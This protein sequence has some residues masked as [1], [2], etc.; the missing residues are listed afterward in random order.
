MAGDNGYIDEFHDHDSLG[1][2][3]D[4]SMDDDVCATPSFKPD[5]DM[6]P[7]WSA[8][9]TML[10]KYRGMDVPGDDS[11]FDVPLE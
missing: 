2:S 6:G 5:G 1:S 8:N 10:P 7:D 3:E 9:G 11:D 4:E